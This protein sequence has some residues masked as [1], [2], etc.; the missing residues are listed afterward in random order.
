[1]LVNKKFAITIAISKLICEFLEEKQIPLFDSDILR[2]NDTLN[3][4]EFPASDNSPAL[5][6]IENRP[7]NGHFGAI[8]SMF[9]KA[10]VT[11]AVR[12][13]H[14]LGIPLAYLHL[15]Y[16]YE[17]A[18]K[19][20]NSSTATFVI[21]PTSIIYEDRFEIAPEALFH[22]IINYRDRIVTRS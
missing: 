6:V 5:N 21:F 9:R 1:M 12:M 13:T 10:Q 19:G 8:S 17:T 14:T 7:L 20:Q 3:R 18:S 16:T 15:K 2:F 22:D 11:V 4:Y